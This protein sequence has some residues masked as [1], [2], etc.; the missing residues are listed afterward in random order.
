MFSSKFLWSSPL[1]YCHFRVQNGRRDLEHLVA[2][3]V[4]TG[5]WRKP[6]GGPLGYLV[7]THW[8]LVY[9]QGCLNLKHPWYNHIEYPGPYF[10]IFSLAFIWNIV[11]F[12]P[13]SEQVI[14]FNIFQK[15]RQPCYAWQ[16][17][18]VTVWLRGSSVPRPHC[19]TSSLE[20]KVGLP[21]SSP[22]DP[23]NPLSHGRCACGNLELVISDTLSTDNL[24]IPCKITLRLI[25][26]NFTDD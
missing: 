7:V 22:C 9:K 21:I 19:A 20:V 1:P 12:L 5:Q 23:L 4:L 2:L 14:A 24:R 10:I 8:T 18:N 26:Q 11:S 17:Q 13:K 16:V 25:P 15:S 6:T 3:R